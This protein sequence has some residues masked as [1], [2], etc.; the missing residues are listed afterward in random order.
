MFLF[1]DKAEFEGE[2]LVLGRGIKLFEK[3]VNDWIST[4]SINL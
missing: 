3:V 4:A 1:R 2:K